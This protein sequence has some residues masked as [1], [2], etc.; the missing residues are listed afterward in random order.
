[1]T[2]QPTRYREVVLTPLPLSPKNFVKKQDLR[3]CYTE[4]TEE[5]RREMQIDELRHFVKRKKSKSA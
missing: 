2:D 4:S 1:M 5:A 3:T